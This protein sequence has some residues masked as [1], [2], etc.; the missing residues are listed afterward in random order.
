MLLCYAASMVTPYLSHLTW[1]FM[2]QD[3]FRYYYVS[4]LHLYGYGVLTVILVLVLGLGF[5]YYFIFCDR[6]M[7]Y[8]PSF[9]LYRPFPFNNSLSLQTCW[10]PGNQEVVFS[11]I[12]TIFQGLTVQLLGILLLVLC[13]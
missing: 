13:V 5:G 7:K 8:C 4:V 10:A 12:S 3:M 1:Y 11:S 9:V 2:Y 6:Y